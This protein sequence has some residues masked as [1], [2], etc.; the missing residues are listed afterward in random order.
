[1]NIFIGCSSSVNIAEEYLKLT[2]SLTSKLT[3]LPLNLVFGASSS[4]MMGICYQAFKSKKITAVTVKEY[5]EDL[6]NLPLA[7]SLIVDNTFQR[8]NK[9]FELSDI[10]LILPGG[11]G[12]LAE[13]FSLLEEFRTSKPDKLFLIYNYRGYYNQLL[14]LLD[15]IIEQKF[16]T[17]ELK[18]YFH[19]INEEDEII[20]LI[21]ERFYERN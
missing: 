1:M 16:A 12:T 13:F 9:I 21:K 15:N 2:K 6:K 5:Q 3:E 18:K 11:S 10:F 17:E 8:I 7:E 19:V 20:R 4:S 14:A